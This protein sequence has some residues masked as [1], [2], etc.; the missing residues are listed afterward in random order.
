MQGF[1]PETKTDTFGFRDFGKIYF[2]KIFFVSLFSEMHSI[3][4]EPN[5]KTLNI[6]KPKT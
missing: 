1:V 3:I 6:M 5:G 2:G 4:G